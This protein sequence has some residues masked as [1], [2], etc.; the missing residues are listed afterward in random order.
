MKEATG[1]VSMTMVTIVAI[2]VIG[3][4][5]AAMWNPIKNWISKNF[6]NAANNTQGSVTNTDMPF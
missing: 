6:T 5:L 4:I 3:T 2:A 1:E